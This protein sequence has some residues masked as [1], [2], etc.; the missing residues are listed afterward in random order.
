MMSWGAT[1]SQQKSKPSLAE[2]FKKAYSKGV[3]KVGIYGPPKTGKTFFALTAPEPIAVI[4]TEFGTWPVI[5]THFKDK[6]IRV[7]EVNVLDD[8]GEIDPDQTIR[9]IEMAVTAIARDTEIRTVVLDSGTDLWSFMHMW[10]DRIAKKTSIGTIVRTEWGK[11]N[12]RYRTIVTKLRAIDKHLIFTGHEKPVYTESGQETKLTKPDWQR[13]TTYWFDVILHTGK[14][15]Q[16]NGWEFHLTVEDIRFMQIR[17]HTI[18]MPT[19]DK[20][21][22]WLK[23]IGITIVEGTT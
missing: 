6:D 13:D 3:L 11:A 15:A 19:W 14:K 5:A 12:A 9:Q 17:P 2:L 18:T 23:S 21:I 7:F 16:P 22:A 4:D 20:L 1:G 8:E 10:L